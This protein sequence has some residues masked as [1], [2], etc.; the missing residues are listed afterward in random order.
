MSA[1][2]R[3]CGTP[4][5]TLPDFHI[6]SCVGTTTEHV[7]A[8]AKR[9]ASIDRLSPSFGRNQPLQ[10]PQ[11]KKTKST[12]A[13]G[14]E[15]TVDMILACRA[16]APSGELEYVV[17]WEGRTPSDDSWVR[18]HNIE[19]TAID[20]FYNSGYLRAPWAA[21]K[22]SMLADPERVPKYLIEK[23]LETRPA[24]AGS[25]R[26]AQSKVQWLGYP[27]W[28]SW[29]DTDKLLQPMPRPPRQQPSR[30]APHATTPGPAREA[31]PRG[32][33][34]PEPATA[35]PAAAAALEAAA[36]RHHHNNA[37]MLLPDGV[38]LGMAGV[39]RLLVEYKLEAY[40]EAFERLGYDDLGFLLLLS[41]QGRLADTLV[42]EIGMKPGHATKFATILA[43]GKGMWE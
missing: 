27:K 20:E 9:C 30:G 17:R 10:Q 3:T 4:G 5:C 12:M 23:V 16:H 11:K 15:Y 36:W 13:S 35:E 34:L 24:D 38:D 19:E 41:D 43:R 39:R 28:S 40:A 42:K 26:P 2:K 8:G 29:I 21:R 31:V 14:E 1:M 25:T 37:P 7:V 18:E 32:A 22:K 6:G 33:A